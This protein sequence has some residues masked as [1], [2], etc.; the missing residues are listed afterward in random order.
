MN[1][2]DINRLMA[3]KVVEKDRR[4]YREEYSI[5]KPSIAFL[6]SVCAVGVMLVLT[7]FAA[8]SR[9]IIEQQFD[10]RLQEELWKHNE[11]A[12]RLKE[13]EKK[14]DDLLLR[15]LLEY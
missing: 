9:A 7:F 11:I 1:K 6:T 3:E 12:R 14:H 5:K 2:H 13:L 8:T 4:Q 10:E 15:L